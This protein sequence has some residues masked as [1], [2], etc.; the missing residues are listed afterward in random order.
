MKFIYKIFLAALFFVLP[1]VFV[2]ASK[3]SAQDEPLIPDFQRSWGA[4]NEWYAVNPV[5]ETFHAR[6]PQADPDSVKDGWWQ[7]GNFR[8]W[9]PVGWEPDY[10]FFNGTRDYGFTQAERFLARHPDSGS[11]KFLADASGKPVKKR[12]KT[13]V[14]VPEDGV[15]NFQ[16]FAWF[17]QYNGAS[18]NVKL[19]MEVWVNG[20]LVV[21]PS[22]AVPVKNTWQEL[23]ANLFLFERDEVKVVLVADQQNESNEGLMDAYFTLQP[24]GM[25]VKQ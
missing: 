20:V 11:I 22:V 4:L 25:G 16:S 14:E 1:V 17:S 6:N 19:A 21:D 5:R 13:T 2:S 23:S 8:D 3:V 15:Y 24:G 9:M 10:E 12:M 18:R 7:D